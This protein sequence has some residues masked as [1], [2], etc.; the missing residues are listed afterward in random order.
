MIKTIEQLTAELAQM[1]TKQSEL[2][3]QL[4]ALKSNPEVWEPSRGK[5]CL[6]ACSQE[7]DSSRFWV[8]AVNY[9]AGDDQTDDAAACL[10][11]PTVEIA[12]TAAAY[13]NWYRAL[14]KLAS[15]C[16]EGGEIGGRYEI[17]VSTETDNFFIARSLSGGAQMLFTESGAEKA[18]KIL[19]RQNG[20]LAGQKCPF[21]Q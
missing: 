10:E 1:R 13:L 15:D 8:K 3:A 5:A 2:E 18:A 7:S 14:V 20:V 19:N 6:A 12:G 17:F 4:Q 16:N 11:Y 9:V 21:I